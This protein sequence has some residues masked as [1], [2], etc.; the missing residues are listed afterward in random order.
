MIWLYTN[1]SLAFAEPLLGVVEVHLSRLGSCA[2]SLSSSKSS[3]D[4]SMPHGGSSGRSG[5][6]GGAFIFLLCPLVGWRALLTPTDDADAIIPTCKSWMI[7]N[8]LLCRY[9]RYMSQHA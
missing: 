6:D 5:G 2:A 1:G 4:V 3:E 7:A 9:A 8:A